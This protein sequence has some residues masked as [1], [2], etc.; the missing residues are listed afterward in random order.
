MTVKRPLEERFW[1]KVEKTDGC[2]IWKSGVNHSGY[3]K[4]TLDG[5]NR[6]LPAH[7]VAWMITHGEMPKSSVYVLHICDKPLC[8]NPD[9]LFLGTAKDNALDALKKGRMNPKPYCQKLTLEQVLEIRQRYSLGE[10]YSKIAEAYSI[11]KTN[12]ACI[13]KHKTWKDYPKWLE[14]M[15]QGE[16]QP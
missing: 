8:V 5:K 16:K 12:V 11:D 7:R 6:S 10:S 14:T 13:V 3:G 4:F 15:N 1:E 2:W 9:H